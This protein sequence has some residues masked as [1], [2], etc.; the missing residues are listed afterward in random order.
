M[1]LLSLGLA[2]TLSVLGG[3]LGLYI[4]VRLSSNPNPEY[5]KMP[6]REGFY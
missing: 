2:P 5:T 6:E 3:L 4:L 1:A